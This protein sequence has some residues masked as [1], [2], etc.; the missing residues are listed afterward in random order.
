MAV[1]KSST[2]GQYPVVWI[3]ASAHN[4]HQGHIPNVQLLKIFVA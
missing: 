4:Q 3:P 2:P 1:F